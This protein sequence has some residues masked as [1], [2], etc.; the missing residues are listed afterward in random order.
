MSGSSDTRIDAILEVLLAFARQDFSKKAP[1]SERLDEIDAL[2]TGLNMLAEELDGQVA[3]RRELEAAYGALKEAQAK[4]VHSEKLAAIG[5]IASS[6]A[7]EINN[8]A[9][10]VL[11]SLDVI[12]LRLAELRAPLISPAPLEASRGRLLSALGEAETFLAD[13]QDGMT[14]IRGVTGDLRTFSRADGDSVEPLHLDEVVRSACNLSRAALRHRASISLSLQSDAVVSGNRG[15][16][17]QVVTNLLL[18]AVQ[19]LP[20]QGPAEIRVETRAQGDTAL[21]AVEDSGPGVPEALRGRVFEPFFT[22]KPAG[23]GTGLG[24]SLVA[25]IVQRHGGKVEVRDGSLRGARFEVRLPRVLL[26]PAPGRAPAVG[27]GSERLRLLIVDDEPRLLRS[28]ALLLGPDH[29]VLLAE[30]GAQALAV[31]EHDHAFDAVLLDLQMPEVDGVAVFERIRA[32]WPE[33]VARVIF[34]SGG[35]VHP[36]VR[37]FLE[38][39]P[40][41]MLEKPVR[42]E[43]LR[44]AID[45]VRGRGSSGVGPD[46]GSAG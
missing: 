1:V 23:L 15:R 22:T 39:N 11:A 30:G 6:V 10:W 41:R 3:S 26:Q 12:R 13:A 4:L 20:E 9:S 14:R 17:G 16:L 7:H 42:M 38:R 40:V 27:L 24:L 25:E 36:H 34:C 44:A 33:L 21:L 31:L 18:N 5:Q 28:Y 32:R 35:A 46:L 45:Q 37:D 2:A 8:P 19:A 43:G 29:D